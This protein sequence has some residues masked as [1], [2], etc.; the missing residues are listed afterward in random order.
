MLYR[1]CLFFLI[2]SRFICLHCGIDSCVV[3][4]CSEEGRT[5]NASA[6]AKPAPL[7]KR[8]FQ[9]PGVCDIQSTIR[10]SAAALLPVAVQ[11]SV[12]CP[13][14]L[15]EIV[16]PVEAAGPRSHILQNIS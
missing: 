4:V 2:L 6:S 3:P 9:S 1:L 16:L 13:D 8:E 5:G 11:L 14:R 12:L 7:G 10:G 15:Q